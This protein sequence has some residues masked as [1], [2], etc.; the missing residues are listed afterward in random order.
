MGGC[1]SQN[2]GKP[3]TTEQ[4]KQTSPTSPV[5]QVKKLTPEE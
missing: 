3:Q 1:A 2:K 5:K 4:G